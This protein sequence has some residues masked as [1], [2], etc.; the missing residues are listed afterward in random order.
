L[1]STVSGEA[2]LIFV[3]VSIAVGN[4]PPSALRTPLWVVLQ[5]RTTPLLSFL[6]SVAPSM[7][8]NSSPC[9]TV[10][11]SQSCPW[12]A[13]FYVRGP[14]HTVGLRNKCQR[15]PKRDPV[16]FQVMP[17]PRHLASPRSPASS[18]IVYGP[19][20]SFQYCLLCVTLTSIVSKLMNS[21]PVTH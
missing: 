9:R 13:V 16:A 18:G 1:D 20:L 14:G 12:V 11:L 5:S 21:L 3:T 10:S 2:G 17:L 7:V 8:H 4:Q 15:T 6:C 19:S